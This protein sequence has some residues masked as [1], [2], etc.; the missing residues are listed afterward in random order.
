EYP[1]DTQ[2][3]KT[4]AQI[5][6]LKNQTDEA[7]KITTALLKSDSSDP[8]S[9]VLRGQ[10]ELRQGHVNDATQTFQ[11]A[12]SGAPNNAMAHFQMGLAY[13]AASNLSQA[14]LQWRRAAQLQPRMV[15]P[16]RALAN[17][18]LHKGDASMLSDAGARLIQIEP[19]AAEGYIFHAVAL[20]YSKDAAGAEADLKK[21]ME[22]A[23]KNP[24][25]YARMGDL[26]MAEKKPEDAEKY[27]RQALAL[28]P[29]ATDALTGLV[30]VQLERKDSAKAL[31]VVQQQIALVPDNSVFYTLLGQVELRD[32]DS[33]K[34]IA[35]FEKATELDKNNVPAFL[36]L[37]GT[38][39]AQGSVDQAIAGYQTALQNNPRDLRVYIALGSLLETRGEWQKAED[40]YQKALQIQPDYPLAANNLSYL[41]L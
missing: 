12:I 7:S 26:R 33:A 16:Q 10:I 17:L 4:Y 24:A 8:D 36:F 11:K 30:N 13:A 14:E 23:P 39:V 9:L 40:L 19:T 25:G 38:Q 3:S 29:A 35:A 5:L 34:A 2:V 15:E 28:N 31:Q 27:Y 1:R 20:F 41:M 18:G 32:K 37:S 6:I 21:A 22:F